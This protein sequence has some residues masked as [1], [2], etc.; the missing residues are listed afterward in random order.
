MLMIKLDP[1]IEKQ[2]SELVERSGIS[3]D[4][5]V[6]QAL[7]E[8]IEEAEDNAF[9]KEA[10]RDPDFGQRVSLEQMKRELGLDS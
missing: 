10:R 1:E 3:L 5:F 2:I 9:L 8:K 4:A 7:I 6:R